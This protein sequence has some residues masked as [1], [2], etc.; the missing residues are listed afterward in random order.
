[1]ARAKRRTRKKASKK[2]APSASRKTTVMT[3]AV[4]D[5]LMKVHEGT[6]K[7]EEAKAD[8]H[9]KAFA[10]KLIAHIM[11]EA[12]IKGPEW[13]VK[14][15]LGAS[16]KKKADAARKRAKKAASAARSRAKKKI[17]AAKKKSR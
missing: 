10:A 13:S 1:M 15:K 17:A 14:K 2:K 16:A 5:A 4:R 7:A 11:K 9:L 12:G 6:K 8:A 3:A